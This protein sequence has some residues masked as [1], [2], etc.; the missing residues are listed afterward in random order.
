[1]LLVLTIPAA[2]GELYEDFRCHDQG[3]VNRA[4]VEDTHWL[5]VDLSLAF[6]EHLRYFDVLEPASSEP[7]DPDTTHV[8]LAAR[9]GHGHEQPNQ[10][11][12]NM[13]LVEAE[14]EAKP[15]V[16]LVI[17]DRGFAANAFMRKM[18]GAI[19]AFGGEYI[20][21]SEQE[22]EWNDPRDG[23]HVVSSPDLSAVRQGAIMEPP[24]GYRLETGSW[25]QK[26]DR[27][28]G[29][30]FDGLHEGHADARGGQAG[31]MMFD[32]KLSA[33]WWRGRFLVYA[34]A[35]LKQYGGRFVVVARSR[36]PEAFGED[37]YEPFE[38]IRIDGYDTEGWGNV[39]FLGV[40]THP[41]EPGMLMG[42]MPVNFGVPGE[43]NGDGDG[44]ISLS[45]SCDGVRWSRLTHLIRSVGLEGRTYDHPVDGVLR[46]A[47]GSVSFFIHKNVLGISPHAPEQSRIVRYRLM[48]TPLRALT[49][50]ARSELGG[51][52]PA[53]PPTAPPPHRPPQPPPPH[54]PPPSLPSPSA[55]R[56]FSPP[57]LPPPSRS[58]LPPPPHPML[59]LGMAKSHATSE[60]SSAATLATLAGMD[61]DG[62]DSLV[63]LAVALLSGLAAFCASFQVVQLRWRQHS[64]RSR[65]DHATRVAPLEKG[66]A[67]G[68]ARVGRAVRAAVAGNAPPRHHRLKPEDDDDDAPGVT[69]GAAAA[70]ARASTARGAAAG[71]GRG[72]PHHAPVSKPSPQCARSWEEDEKEAASLGRSPSLWEADMKLARAHAGAVSALK[73]AK[74]KT[75][76]DDI[77]L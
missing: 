52:C 12:W 76:I 13:K 3:C 72:R 9:G 60:R 6:D 65:A 68:V 43:G 36:G 11:T 37:A 33:V 29:F 18:N 32:G 74:A 4:L 23:V 19:Y 30:V 63:W 47:D 17:Y 1:M 7:F 50:R 59:P 38:R 44:Y 64:Q 49:M 67:R 24:H 27:R 51:S 21:V 55:P 66:K 28:H 62:G 45:F 20:D 14:E 35:N 48:A 15:R 41:H 46:E 42:L 61:V 77:D 22:W 71:R 56:I 53:N 2:L 10:E 8:V 58:P 75:S 70:S 73:S 25:Q 34:R 39:Y 26:V 69:P 16:K 54:R 40:D 31:F 5:F 57:P